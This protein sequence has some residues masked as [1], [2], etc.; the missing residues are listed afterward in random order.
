MSDWVELDNETRWYDQAM[1][2]CDLCGRMIAQRLFR[3]EFEGGL[4]TFCGEGCARLYQDY[5]LTEG[6]SEPRPSNVG[7]MYAQLMVT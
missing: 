6:R 1:I 5:W 2:H 3:A 7:E 4:K